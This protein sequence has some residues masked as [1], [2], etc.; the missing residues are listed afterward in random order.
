MKKR[1]RFTPEQKEKMKTRTIAMLKAGHSQQHAARTLGTT[2]TTI[3][4]LI[5]G[6]EYPGQRRASAKQSKKLG[7][8]RAG[9]RTGALHGPVAQLAEKHARLEAIERQIA[10]LAGERAALKKAMR[11]IY[12]RV[13]KAIFKS[14]E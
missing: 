4:K 10:E 11:A 5:Q 2:V 3:R 1:V 6:L 14:G 7:K 9:K 13:G 12:E 8:G